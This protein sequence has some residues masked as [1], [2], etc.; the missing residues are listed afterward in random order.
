[1]TADDYTQAEVVRALTRIE[2]G[3]EELGRKFDGLTDK[4]VTTDV[5][6]LR[7]GAVERDVKE[8]K[9]ATAAAQATADSR[10][11]SALTVTV[12]VAAIVATVVNIIPFFTK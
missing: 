10:R 7:V 9:A 5:F 4:F 3:Q 12:G 11:P 6:E 1:M 8:G 2:K